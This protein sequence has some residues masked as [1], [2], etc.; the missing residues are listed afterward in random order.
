MIFSTQTILGSTTY[1]VPSGPYDGSSL[2]FFGY[3]VPA[4]NYYKGQGSTQTIILDLSNV[5]GIISVQASLGTLSEQASWS[6]LF[7]FGNL[8]DTR[9]MAPS[10]AQTGVFPFTQ[11]GNYV[12]I[13]AEIIGFTAGTINSIIVNY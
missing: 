6:E 5:N 2:D 4:A 11:I 13:R 12:W 9:P 1:G 10:N 7:R 8:T 3:S